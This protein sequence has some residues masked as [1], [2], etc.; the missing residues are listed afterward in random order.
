MKKSLFTALIITLFVVPVCTAEKSI[1]LTLAQ[2]EAERKAIITETVAPT[3][4]QAEEF[5]Q[6]Y[7][8]YRGGVKMLTDRVLEVVEEFAAA[9]G[10]LS[11]N[12]SAALVLEVM[13]IEKRRANLKQTYL[14]K[15]QKI[16]DPRQV[17]RWYQAERKM[18][19]VIRAEMA[20]S[21]PFNDLASRT[22]EELTGAEIRSSREALALAIVQ[23]LENQTDTFLYVY[24]IYNKKIVK[25]EDRISDLIA[26]YVKSDATLSDEQAERMTKESAEIDVAR[27]KALETM[28]YSLRADLTGK[29]MARLM[30]GELKMNAITD[31]VLA[32]AIPLHP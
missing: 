2:I 29:Q 25:L 30:Q 17:V 21:I 20:A 4:Q 10:A 12:R 22:G 8:Q 16:L 11:G 31:L 3:E 27:V 14:K 26:E 18:D 6:T 28:I 23:P 5:W 13:D 9:E 24:R 19:S 1:G 32:A 15:F 7:W